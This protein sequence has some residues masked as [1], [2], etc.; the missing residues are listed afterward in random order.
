[1]QSPKLD[2]L[3]QIC[4]RQFMDDRGKQ[5]LEKIVGRIVENQRRSM[6]SCN[7]VDEASERRL[8]RERHQLT[9][10][11]T[12]YREMFVQLQKYCKPDGPASSDAVKRR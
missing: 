4:L 5:I 11:E 7:P 3:D 2:D 8:I 12:L 9:G 10:A 6:L 1:M